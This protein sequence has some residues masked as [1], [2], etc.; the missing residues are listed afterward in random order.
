V[1]VQ[2]S[3]VSTLPFHDLD[4]NLPPILDRHIRYISCSATIAQPFKH[5]KSIFGI[6][7]GINVLCSGLQ[8]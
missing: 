5:M 8:H 1:F 7:V 2:P 3:E 4:R 6:E